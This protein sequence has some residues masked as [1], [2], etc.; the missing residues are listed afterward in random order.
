[1]KDRDTIIREQRE[2][3][4]YEREHRTEIMIDRL[5]KMT[6][7]TDD[8]ISREWFFINTFRSHRIKAV[9]AAN[10][11]GNIWNLFAF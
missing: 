5:K 4:M 11:S 2:K 10:D 7:F 3:A 6:K 1:M 8:C 9:G